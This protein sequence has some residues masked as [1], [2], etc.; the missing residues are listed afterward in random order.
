ML[1]TDRNYRLFFILY[2]I[3]SSCTTVSFFAQTPP[4]VLLK[5]FLQ[6]PDLCL[7]IHFLFILQRHAVVD[8]LQIFPQFS[9]P[10]L[11]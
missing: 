9:M 6:S 7:K 10:A 5:R 4:P 2:Y 11:L 8:A 3:P 1:F